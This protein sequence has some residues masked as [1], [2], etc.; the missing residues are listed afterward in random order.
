MN[1]LAT[2][3]LFACIGVVLAWALRIPI[4][5]LA[6]AG[7][8]FCLWLLPPM[9]ALVAWLPAWPGTFWPSTML[10]TSP[11]LHLPAFLVTAQ[12]G[13]S[14]AD[15]AGI[16]LAQSLLALWL[17]G[18]C[19]MLA[20]LVWHCVCIVRQSS[21]LP[22]PMQAALNRHLKGMDLHD[23]RQHP[24]GPAVCWLPRHH[25]LLPA[26]F[27]HRFTEPQLAQVL[28]HEGMHLARRDPIWSLGAELVLAALWFFPLAWLAMNRFRLDQ[29]LA[30]DAAMMRVR[31]GQAG[32]YARALLSGAATT[33]VLAATSPW[34][35][36]AQLKERLTM[37]RNH[38]ETILQRRAGYAVLGCVLSCLALT[39]HAALPAAADVTAQMEA[40]HTSPVP[41]AVPTPPIP[42]ASPP[43][44]PPP[45]PPAPPAPP[46]TP[47]VPP[48]PPA[49]GMP[50]S[51]SHAA[52]VIPASRV[53][54]SPNNYPLDAIRN[55]ADGTVVVE[56]LIGV[57]GYPLALSYDR[58]HSVTTKSLIAAAMARVANWEFEPVRDANGASQE[59]WA[60]VPVT[61]TLD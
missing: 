23:V 3:L 29:E 60:Q 53:E 56:V 4:R 10:G 58:E 17:L 61:F 6:G 57:N 55:R 38:S 35:S 25:L 8:A 54:Q 28:A 18:A 21:P 33:R 39:A 40:S 19:L 34:L 49:L 42:P 36:H 16:R 41:P 9:L 32:C 24:A 52:R 7:P 5:K 31:P 50:E 12:A 11:M 44:P 13:M 47:P 26:D 20:R 1:D 59:A 48:A 43:P 14:L 51:G 37:I 2:S 27:Q 45:P 46:S 22:K 30:C 15:V